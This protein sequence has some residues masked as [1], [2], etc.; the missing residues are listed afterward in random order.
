MSVFDEMGGYWAEIADQNQTERQIK[1]V[2]TP[3]KPTGLVLDLACGTGRHL[4][5]LGKEGYDIIGLDI[6]RNLLRIAKSRWSGAQV[7]RGDMRF[8]PFKPEAFSAAVSM[9]TSVGYLPVGAG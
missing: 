1:F 2:K 7:V 9:D 3:L 4:I 6:S 8:L 5:P